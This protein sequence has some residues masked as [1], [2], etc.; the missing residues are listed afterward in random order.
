M[1]TNIFQD[2][3]TSSFL[4]SGKV[5]PQE[6]GSCY[7]DQ[8]KLM[9]AG[10]SVMPGSMSKA[11]V[12]VWQTVVFVCRRPQSLPWCLL[13]IAVRRRGPTDFCHCN[14]VARRE[15]PIQQSLYKGLNKK[16]IPSILNAA[17][18]PLTAARQ[19]P[20]EISAT[21]GCHMLSGKPRML[22]RSC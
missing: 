15:E 14:L 3:M 13:F 7:S 20:W 8:L 2:N 5:P 22:A 12:D 17:S 18:Q 4:V 19:I 10:L 1:I 21:Q 6:H 16:L 11:S 9:D